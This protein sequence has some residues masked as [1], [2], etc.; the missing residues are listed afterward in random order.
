[1]LNIVIASSSG[2]TD[3]EKRTFDGIDYE[4]VSDKW[5]YTEPSGWICAKITDK[6]IKNLKIFNSDMEKQGKSKDKVKIE[7]KNMAFKLLGFETTKQNSLKSSQ[8]ET[9]NETSYEKTICRFYSF[10]I[11]TYM[12]FDIQAGNDILDPIIN[13]TS[14][15]Y[16]WSSGMICPSSSYVFYNAT[17]FNGAGFPPATDYVYTTEYVG[18]KYVN[19]TGFYVSTSG[20]PSAGFAYILIIYYMDGTYSYETPTPP[21][22]PA[23]VVDANP[24]PYKKVSHI[25]WGF[26]STFGRSFSI[27][28]RFATSMCFD[29]TINESFTTSFSHPFVSN[30]TYDS[31]CE[32]NNVSFYLMNGTVLNGITSFNYSGTNFTMQVNETNCSWINL[33][34]EQLPLAGLKVNIFN[35]NGNLILENITTRLSLDNGTYY[36]N[37][38]DTGMAFFENLN[39]DSYTLE[40]TGTNYLTTSYNLTSE[41]FLNF[42]GSTSYNTTFNAFLISN[43]G[44]ALTTIT[45][46][47]QVGQYVDEALITITGNVN[48]TWQ[49]ITQ[50]T[51]DSTGT[52]VLSLEIGKT[53][54]TY[55]TKS[56][57]VLQQGT[58]MPTGNPYDV[59]LILYKDV[60]T[61][62]TTPMSCIDSFSFSPTQLNL[63]NTLRN[64]T[65]DVLSLKGNI[66]YFGVYHNASKYLNLSIFNT[67]GVANLQLNLTSYSGQ[68]NIMY[69]F[70]CY[71]QNLY[72]KNVS[73]YLS[74]TLPTNNA[75]FEQGMA[76]I[77]SGSTSF[78]VKM[79]IILITIVVALLVAWEIGMPPIS[80]GFIV[81]IVLCFFTFYP[82]QWIPQIFTI[83]GGVALVGGSLYAGQGG[84]MY[85]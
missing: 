16:N 42:T 39:P 30:I 47:T 63:N 64:F 48:G 85:G 84:E 29:N 34:F 72:V 23:N 27:V 79:I 74:G 62:I 32:Q 33:L 24:N 17:A 55:I 19:N 22:T 20:D 68:L 52:I 14:L 41:Y 21:I 38:T 37:I 81:T 35:T 40:L 1:M 58:I 43:V 71:N 75:T 76:D 18:G 45:I 70:K 36:Q 15:N 56:G 7:S 31:G 44:T 6:T 73:Y 54:R 2:K 66:E 53:Y 65:I 50:K 9:F 67:G 10:P 59:V 3:L 46:I 12:K 4:I 78:L 5:V 83:V 13:L 49:T 51:T 77:N 8:K 80:Y 25:T 26:I 61:N 28:N 60:V 11:G 82:V 57:Y 69:F